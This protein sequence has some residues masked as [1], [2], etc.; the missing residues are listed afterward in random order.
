[1]YLDHDHPVLAGQ[2]EFAAAVS[3]PGDVL[4]QLRDHHEHDVDG[5]GRGAGE[6]R[7]G[8][9]AHRGRRLVVREGQA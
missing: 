3:V 1:V 4:D 9:P 8:L 6:N 2:P 7:L 5:V